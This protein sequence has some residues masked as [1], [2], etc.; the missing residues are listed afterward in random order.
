MQV[1]AL[2]SVSREGVRYR[3]PANRW[4]LGQWPPHPIPGEDADAM[5]AQEPFVGTGDDYVRPIC[6]NW[7][8]TKR[9]RGVHQH[10]GADLRSSLG[11]RIYVMAEPR[12]GNSRG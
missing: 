7:E 9:L 10:K 1:V 3:S 4:W 11:Q 12:L 6:G 2:K 5:A 8:R